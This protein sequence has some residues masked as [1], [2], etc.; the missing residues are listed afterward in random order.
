MVVREVILRRQF[1]RVFCGHGHDSFTCPCETVPVE[2]VIF[3]GVFI[4]LN[5]KGPKLEFML[6]QSQIDLGRHRLR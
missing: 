5:I 4:F 2:S 3:K 6:K 1:Y